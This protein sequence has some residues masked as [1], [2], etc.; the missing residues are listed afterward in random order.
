MLTGV[1]T[2][3]LAAACRGASVGSLAGEA[4]PAHVGTQGVGGAGEAG[5]ED[6]LKGGSR[7]GV[8]SWIQGGTCW[9]LMRLAL[10]TAHHFTG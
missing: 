5:K 8:G 3:G 1:A 4:G 7:T 2:F 9:D 10:K 6:V